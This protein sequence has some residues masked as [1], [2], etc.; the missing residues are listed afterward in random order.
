MAP[1]N[2][3]RLTI[4]LRKDLL[5]E[6]DKAIDG[7][8]IRNRSHAIEYVLGKSLN[9]SVRKAFILAG[10]YGIQM[11][12]FTYELPKPMILVKGRPILEYIIEQL[13]DHGIRE[14]VILTGP[15]SNKI[16]EHFRDGS[17]FG[18]SITYIDEEK[19]AGTGGSLKK[20]EKIFKEPFLLLYGDVLA[21]I[22]LH[23]FI[24]FHQSSHN[25]A[26]VALSTA[27]DTS[28]YGL[29]K[30]RGSR[31]VDFIEKPNKMDKLSGLVSAGIYV[32]E[33]SIFEH[34]SGQSKNFSL[35]KEVFP[36]L[37]KIGKIGG[38]PFEGQW[39]DVSTPEI[40]EKVIKEWKN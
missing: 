5:Q 23:D 26:S 33:P 30:M 17:Q 29:V 38:Y 34:L 3:V 24:E 28:G 9:P 12:P 40:Y 16:I 18:V 2:R 8:R 20:G 4:T 11:R 1:R 15:L 14:I 25:I 7:A 31:I 21:D 10:G 6:I 36:Q 13:R 35:E 19:P 39:F 37:I 27:V 32:F 22:N